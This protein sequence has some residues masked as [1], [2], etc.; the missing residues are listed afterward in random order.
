MIIYNTTF[1]VENG[2]VSEFLKW[3]RLT[4]IPAALADGTLAA[5]QLA[6]IMINQPDGTSYAMQ[7]QANS[8]GALQRWN[9]STGKALMQQLSARFGS[10]AVSF[11]T[12]MEK[13]DIE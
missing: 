5:P 2:T 1:N 11:S 3:M 12:M 9:Q 4:Y 13:I 6:R 8:L 7:F 10:N